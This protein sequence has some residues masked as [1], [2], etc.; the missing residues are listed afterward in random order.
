MSIAANARLALLAALLTAACQAG[1][2]GSVA[3]VRDSAEVAIVENPAP[4]PRGVPWTL[5]TTPVLDLGAD[6]SD[7][8]QEFS[9]VLT[10]VRLQGGEIVVAN[11]G[12]SE[13]RYFD[14][15]GQW[16]RSVG[17]AG[18]G[19]GEF[20]RLGW[21]ALGTG[22]TLRTYD[23]GLHRLSIFAPEG[24]FVRSVVLESPGPMRGVMPQAVTPT[25]GLLGMAMSFATPGMRSGVFRDT[26]PLFLY[27]EAGTPS[28]SFGWF[29]GA[30]ALIQSDSRSVLATSCPY[31]KEL[32]L[33]VD[34]GAGRVYA[35]SEDRP[36]VS[37]WTPAGRLVRI[38]RWQ[39]EAEP[40][41]EQDRADYIAE[42]RA[43]SRPGEEQ[44]LERTV[45]VI[46]DAKLPATKPAFG[47]LLAGPRGTLW[48][49]GYTEGG[50]DGP[51]PHLVFDSAGR[52]LGS[53]VFPARFTAT[54]IGEDYVLGTWQDADDV[55]HIRLYRLIPS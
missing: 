44:F 20:R 15:T 30:E 29:P 34:L 18:E 35:G 4:A 41:T 53:L 6:P 45:Q 23:W 49:R 40:I 14:T 36:E 42:M 2:R 32:V 8:H 1:D 3:T 28:D 24:A 11:S 31:G 51:V 9:G 10:P 12:T 21:V 54:Q 22:D 25:G 55:T 5:D 46:Q 13:L 7:P 50:A 17:R 52:A 47:G 48:V 39:A 37:V 26:T 33:A 19:P 16:L 27:G 38:I 43:R